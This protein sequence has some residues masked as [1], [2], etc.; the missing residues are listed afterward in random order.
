MDS[1]TDV[2]ENYRV[3]KRAQK[4][5]YRLPITDLSPR[6]LFLFTGWL[7]LEEKARRNLDRTCQLHPSTLLDEAISTPFK[8]QIDLINQVAVNSSWEKRPTLT[9]P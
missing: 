6:C 9:T 7:R 1:A 2:L 8:L 3:L 4:S 5:L